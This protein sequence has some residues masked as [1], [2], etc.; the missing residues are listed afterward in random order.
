MY[1]GRDVARLILME[2]DPCTA[3]TLCRVS[4]AFWRADVDWPRIRENAM[5]LHMERATENA[6]LAIAELRRCERIPGFIG[7]RCPG[8]ENRTNA[9]GLRFH[10]PAYCPC[11]IVPCLECGVRMPIAALTHHHCK[12][13][14]IHSVMSYLWVQFLKLLSHVEFR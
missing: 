5:Y 7:G 11:H 2:C 13:G 8:C 1:F 12:I 10:D 6:E 4:R 9:Y 3:V 14:L